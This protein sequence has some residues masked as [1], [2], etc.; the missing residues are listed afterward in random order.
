MD[1]NTERILATT[2]T[3]YADYHAVKRMYEAKNG[4]WTI[5]PTQDFKV[6]GESNRYTGYDAVLYTPTEYRLEIKSRSEKYHIASFPDLQV[7][8]LK[9]DRL[10]ETGNGILIGI[11]LADAT[12]TV[13]PIRE[14]VFTPSYQFGADTTMGLGDN[15]TKKTK[16]MYSFPL[17]EAKLIPFDVSKWFSDYWRCYFYHYYNLTNR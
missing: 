11:Y 1:G 12:M 16:L 8:K 10:M 4:S 13:W 14:G 9:V 3:E 5:T 7:N 17:S 2:A 15:Q 6:F